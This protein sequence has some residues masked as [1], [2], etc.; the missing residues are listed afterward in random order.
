MRKMSDFIESVFIVLVF[1]M[2]SLK[3]RGGRVPK[4]GLFGRAA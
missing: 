3:M 2:E 4:D 1:V